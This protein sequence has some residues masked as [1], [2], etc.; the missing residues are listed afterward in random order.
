[1]R[2]ALTPTLLGFDD[3]LAMSA[4]PPTADIHRGDG[5][6]RFAPH[7]RTHAPRQTTSLFDHLIGDSEQRRG[8]FTSSLGCL[9]VFDEVELGTENL[10]RNPELKAPTGFADRPPATAR[11]LL[12]GLAL[13][14]PLTASDE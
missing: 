7:Q 13:M 12:A 9:E 2:A 5:H 10:R 4:S 1:L 8:T 6:V 11:E 14:V 3:A